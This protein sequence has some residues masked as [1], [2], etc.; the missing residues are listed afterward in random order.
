MANI[1]IPIG[2]SVA[3]ANTAISA[4][5]PGDSVRFERGGTYV[6]M[7]DI[8]ASGAA[9]NHIIFD[10]YG[11]GADPIITTRTSLPG[12]DT[13]GNW[14]NLGSNV[15]SKSVPFNNQSTDF[16]FWLNG[17]E[18]YKSQTSATV[19]STKR[20]SYNVVYAATLYVYA[21]SNPATFYSSIEYN[22]TEYCALQFNFV[23]YVTLQNLDIRGGT[24]GTVD[25]YGSSHLIIQNCH[26]GLDAGKVGIRR[27]G[28]GTCN[29]IIIRDN[30]LDSGDRLVNQ[31][32]YTPYAINDGIYIGTHPT[33]GW[34]IYR[35]TIKDWGHA[36]VDM[37][38][39]IGN[40][41]DI[42]IYDNLLTAENVGYCRAIGYVGIEGGSYTSNKIYRN[43]IYRT[44]IQ[45]QIGCPNLEFYNNV[46]N[47]TRNST[48][49]P[50]AGSGRGIDIS[51]YSSTHALNMKVYNNV[52]ANCASEGLRV[53]RSAGYTSPTGNQIINNIFYNNGDLSPNGYDDAQIVIVEN[54]ANITG[55]TFR[56]NL[57][58]KT[59]ITDRIYY[60]NRNV[61]NE[62]MTL[63][64]FNARNG[65]DSD[66]ISGNIGGDPLFVD[67]NADFAL[68]SG[69]PAVNTGI[70]LGSPYDIAL[71][72]STWPSDVNTGSQ[73]G[74]WNLGAYVDAQTKILMS[75]GK[76]LTHAGKILIR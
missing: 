73:V 63:A 11:S 70:N 49:S 75:G 69:S 6:G 39:I 16:R 14:T 32:Y 35:N 74:A 4:A 33:S 43:L 41:N 50:T 19:N 56:N 12:W 55:N 61:G 24:G 37:N 45:V 38:N 7:V 57:L 20:T 10:A 1:D 53:S 71:I 25:S 52:I 29:D 76:I 15:W 44:S 68:Q 65:V 46:I 5:N 62:F 51:G 9:G 18:Y 54:G 72:A 13:P 36:C 17:S 23:S 27:G 48:N 42:E 67:D 30:V 8:D 60:D 58:Y 40:A 26:I 34:R 2:T 22:G 21:T 66:V 28:S 47:E 59:G 31:D 64:E 3:S